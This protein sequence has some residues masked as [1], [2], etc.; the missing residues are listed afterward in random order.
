MTM[1]CINCSLKALVEG[2]EPPVFEEEPEEHMRRCHPHPI[3]AK[4]ER[5]ELEAKLRA[6]MEKDDGRI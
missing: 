5:A 2:T 6:K 1:I 3:K 4:R